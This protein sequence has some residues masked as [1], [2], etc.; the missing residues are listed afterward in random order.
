[1]VVAALLIGRT[2]YTH[3]PALT[4]RSRAGA[5]AAAR[6]AHVR[7]TFGY[8]HDGAR[9]GMVIGQ[10][11]RAGGRVTTGSTIHLTLSRGPALVSVLN[12]RGEQVR[13]AQQSL[14]GV[15]LRSVVRHV[16]AP[17][18]APGTVVGQTPA[19]GRNV[20][21]GLTVKLS[22]AEVPQWRTVAMF[23]G[24][25]SG[26]VHI[27]GSHWRIVYRMAFNGTCTWLVFCSGPTARVLKAGTGRY[28][29]G[30][31]LQD[32]T[33][34]VQSFATGAGSYAVDVTPG[35]DDAGWSMQVQDDY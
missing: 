25:S 27:I 7:L 15:R 32:G 17:G 35:G 16:P 34:Q 6:R 9:A 30:F 13:D 10:T 11:P 31:G 23:A 24:R 14:R 19:G 4:H 22:V 3:V 28:V 33:G 2:T 12:V 29:A 18:T 5:Q 26:A 21:R 1:M 20:P 8:R